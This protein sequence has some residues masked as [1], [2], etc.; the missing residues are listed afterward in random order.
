MT[1]PTTDQTPCPGSCNHAWRHAEIRLAHHGDP[2]HVDDDGNTIDAEPGQP[3]WCR[4]CADRITATL[5]RVLDLLV[6][7]RTRTDGRL[8]TGRDTGDGTRRGTRT[9][10]PTGSAS[11]DVADE[12]TAW[13][14]DQVDELA[15]HL[16]HATRSRRDTRGRLLHASDAARYLANHAS[17]WLCTPWA[18]E[19]GRD[20]LA[21]VT[22]LERTTGLD[23]LRHRL[24]APCPACDRL[25]LVRD[26]G[27]DLVQCAACRAS[28]DESAYQRLVG[29]LAD[30][31]KRT[32]R[33]RVG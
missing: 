24:K 4:P 16:G 21:W 10:S 28:W 30:E 27:S 2:V 5:P 33:A 26:D 9:G 20:A 32:A 15:D 29:V 25:T 17:A 14:A 23:R 12:V 11:L 19:S 6:E 3:V 22:R 31:Q 13:L 1:S 18:V 8:N 7:A